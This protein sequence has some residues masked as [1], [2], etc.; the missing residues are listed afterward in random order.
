[1]K[2]ILYI[3]IEYEFININYILFLKNCEKKKKNIVI[4]YCYLCYN[5]IISCILFFNVKESFLITL[6]REYMNTSIKKSI[7]AKQYYMP[8]QT[9][10]Y[11]GHV[12]VIMIGL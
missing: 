9:T 6:N 11:H 12:S 7:R 1:M 5:Y 10:C 4:S 2:C 8:T 3:I